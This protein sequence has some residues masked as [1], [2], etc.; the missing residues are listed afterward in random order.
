M[1]APCGLPVVLENVRPAASSSWEIALHAAAVARVGHV[2]VAAAADRGR[3]VQE[4]EPER[5]VRAR[6]PRP[7][8]VELVLLL[9]DRADHVDPVEGDD[10]VVAA[11][12]AV[13]AEEPRVVRDDRAAAGK[14]RVEPR[15][16]LVGR[17][18]VLGDE[19]VVLE[20]SS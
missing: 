18:A 6:R 19:A 8:G 10:G 9:F 17:V 15:E 5:L 13:A 14:R 20:E 12:A 16:L 7:A 4:R 2:P 11:E 3:V 1:T